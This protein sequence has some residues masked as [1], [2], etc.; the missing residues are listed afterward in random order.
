MS[1]INS[2]QC[3]I[4]P[5]YA[6]QLYNA[7]QNSDGDNHNN[8]NNTNNSAATPLSS[9]TFGTWT[10][11]SAII[12][13]Y[14]A[15]HIYDPLVYDIARWTYGIALLHFVSEWL[16]FGTARAQGRFLG[17]LI[18]ASTSLGWMTL[19]KGWYTA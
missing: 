15:Y 4:S 19:Q 9:R 12:R 11:L 10:F 17:P 5:S 8:A 7:S 6:S 13:M 16:V 2:L 18:V 14:A 1:S 3:Y